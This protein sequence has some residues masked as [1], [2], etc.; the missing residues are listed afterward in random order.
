MEDN[1]IENQILASLKENESVNSQALCKELIEKFPEHIHNHQELYSV[2]LS[3]ET[4]TL[5][6]LEK[7]S[8]TVSVL[9]PEGELYLNKGTPE[10][11]YAQVASKHEGMA[12][13]EF[14]K[15]FES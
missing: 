5:I 13:A 8:E 7:K 14:N 11:C 2:L 1:L 12:A 10:F 9:T 6:C 3:L 15:V 4:L